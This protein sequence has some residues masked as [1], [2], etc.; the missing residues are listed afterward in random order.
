LRARLAIRSAIA[1][2][3]PH[4]LPQTGGRLLMHSEILNG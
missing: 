4:D 1:K 2:I 3:A